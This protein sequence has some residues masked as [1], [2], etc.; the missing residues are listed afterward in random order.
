MENSCIVMS[1]IERVINMKLMK[2][3]SLTSFS[4]EEMRTYT[5]DLVEM[6][7]PGVKTICL[8]NWFPFFILAFKESSE[9]PHMVACKNPNPWFLKNLNSFVKLCAGSIDWD[10]LLQKC[11]LVPSY[12]LRFNYVSYVFVLMLPEF[13]F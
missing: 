8:Q 12:Y 3:M 4:R 10:I 5:V 2:I 7:L 11:L 1:Y 9:V 6:D 13:E